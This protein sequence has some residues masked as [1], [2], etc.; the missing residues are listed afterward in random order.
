MRT[1]TKKLKE[2]KHKF[3]KQKYKNEII[4]APSNSTSKMY[5]KKTNI[6]SCCNIQKR[7]KLFRNYSHEVSGEMCFV[8]IELS[9]CRFDADVIRFLILD[10]QILSQLNVYS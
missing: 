7:K 3:Y 5:K 1:T 4:L 8:D 2:K 9:L 6:Y 10:P